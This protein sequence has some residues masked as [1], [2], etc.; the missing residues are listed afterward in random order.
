MQ[1]QPSRPHG[2][3]PA[4]ITALYQYILSQV[5]VGFY[6][7]RQMIFAAVSHLK[8]SELPP[9]PPPSWTWFTKFIKSQPGLHKIKTKP[10]SRARSTAQD[11][12]EV[13]KWFL[14]YKATIEEHQIK[15]KDI[16]NFDETGFWVGCP[17]GEE[18]IVPTHITE[19]SIIILVL[20]NITNKYT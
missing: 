13:E 19:V 17:P 6:P 12:E 20:L 18:V 5:D 9:K 10:I 2:V 1:R 16:H 4:Q 3:S 15:P 8:A 14:G 11:I 7:T